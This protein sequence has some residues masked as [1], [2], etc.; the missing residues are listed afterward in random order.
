[1]EPADSFADLVERADI[2][3]PI[4]AAAIE[5][6]IDYHLAIEDYLASIRA[7]AHRRMETLERLFP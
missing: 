4:L 1:M 6:Q 5:A 7:A 2:A 3:D